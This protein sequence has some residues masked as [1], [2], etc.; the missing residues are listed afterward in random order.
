ML[1]EQIMWLSGKYLQQEIEKHTILGKQLR[2]VDFIGPENCFAFHKG[3]KC[4]LA[5]L[6]LTYINAP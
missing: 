1:L 4:N 2:I 3:K 6:V 5:I